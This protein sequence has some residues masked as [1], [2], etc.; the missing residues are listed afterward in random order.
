MFGYSNT[1]YVTLAAGGIFYRK[2][3][4][5]AHQVCKL[6]T[7]FLEVSILLSSKVNGTQNVEASI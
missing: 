5:V 6:L 3:T 1:I 4:I 2:I 7:T